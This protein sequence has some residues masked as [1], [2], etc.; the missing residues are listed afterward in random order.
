MSRAG[1]T[2]VEIVAAI[3][4]AT[5]VTLLAHRGIHM[6][7][8]LQLRAA[9]TRSSAM[10]AAGVRRQITSWVRAAYLPRDAG[11]LIFS[12]SHGPSAGLQPDDRLSFPTQR[13]DPFREGLATVWLGID[14]DPLTPTAGLV[15]R[16][17]RGASSNAAGGQEPETIDLVPEATGFHVRYRFWTGEGWQW[18]DEWMSSIR[19]PDGL[20]VMILGDSVPGLL[21]A[22]IH[23]IPGGR[24]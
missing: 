11:E 13:P 22:P 6:A 21:R 1:F 7:I 4:I 20:E 23:V 24:Q 9:D 12:G 14:H 19:L 2:L 8:E 17:A 5:L 18:T 10:E 16:V 15:A 3:V